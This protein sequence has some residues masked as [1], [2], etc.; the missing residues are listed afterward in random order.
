MTR[1]ADAIKAR[2]PIDAVISRYVALRPAGNGEL[3]GLCPFH[4][5]KTPS[6]TVTPAKGLYHCFG[7][8]ASGDVISFVQQIEGVDFRAA[9]E[10]L[11][12]EAALPSASP[13]AAKRNGTTNPSA[14]ADDRPEQ[15]EQPRVVATYQYVDESGALL[16]EVQR[17]E[18]GRNGKRKEFRQRRRHPITGSWVW[19]ISAGWYRRG[20]DGDWYVVRGK[21]QDGDDELPEVRRVLYR[22]PAVL[23]AAEVYLVEGEKDVHTIERLG[24]VGTTNAGGA[25]QKWLPEYTAALAGRRVIIIPDNDQPGLKRAEQI[26]RE[27]RGHCSVLFVRLPD[28]AKDITDW[29]DAGHGREDLEHLVAAARREK[30]RAEI[31]A[32]GLLHPTEILTLWDGGQDTFLDP[33]R[34]PK[35]IPTGFSGLDE[36]T[37]GMHPGDLILLAARPAM[38]KT[39]FA[40]NIA[41]HVAER[42]GPVAIFSLEMSRESLLTRL[43]CARAGVDQ[44]RFRAGYLRRDERDALARA[45]DEICQWPLFIDDHPGSGL[46]QIRAK[47]E[48]L[49]SRVGLSLVIIDYL[50]L[51]AGGG[52]ENR[53]QEVGALSRGLKL[54]ARDFRVPFL[55]LSQLSRAPDT[56]PG[57]H[58]PQLSDLRES[59]SLEQDA[60]VVMFIFREEVYKPEREDL[61]GIAEIIVA[62]QRNGPTG[63]KR[64]AFVRALTKFAELEKDRRDDAE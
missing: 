9:V 57:S 41:A 52:G 13:I 33:S 25:A 20:A 17:L 15:K 62:K 42:I 59:G 32:R 36:M 60:D 35:G 6:F 29:V 63:T 43:L 50:Q 46:K 24:F 19:G 14:A 64:L 38:G 4:K 22:L 31:E 37:L 55:V 51:M 10:R 18:P 53:T 44:M 26:E 39:A 21:Q 45:M 61:R 49:R 3:V 40:L 12:A 16:F 30:M 28:G 23:A 1:D 27:L 58:R 2:V 47:L 34:R 5:E 11:A 48:A 56:R 8:E 54:M 7:C